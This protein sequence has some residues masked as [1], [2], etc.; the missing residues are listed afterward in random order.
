M[1]LRFLL[2]K[3]NFQNFPGRACLPALGH[4]LSSLV[5]HD[6][7]ASFTVIGKGEK[8]VWNSLNPILVLTLPYYLG[9]ANKET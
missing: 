2:T 5:S 1:S 3:V 6:Q 8:T 9:S 4:V 7:T